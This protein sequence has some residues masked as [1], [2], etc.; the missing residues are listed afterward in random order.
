MRYPE[1]LGLLTI[2]IGP[3]YR[4]ETPPEIPD[5]NFWVPCPIFP[6]IHRI[7]KMLPERIA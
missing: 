6:K 4:N 1:I 7:S 2:G 3:A 5:W